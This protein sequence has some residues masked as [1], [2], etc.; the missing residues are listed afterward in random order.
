MEQDILSERSMNGKTLK[1]IDLL[2]KRY[3]SDLF[4]IFDS[5]LKIN[6][7]DNVDGG[8]DDDEIDGYGD[9]TIRKKVRAICDIS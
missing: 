7:I 1:K 8:E 3:D 6:L 4:C 5:N 2:M 9:Y